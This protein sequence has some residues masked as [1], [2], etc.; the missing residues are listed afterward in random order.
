MSTDHEAVGRAVERIAYANI[1]WQTLKVVTHGYPKRWTAFVGPITGTTRATPG[2]ALIAL[3]DKIDPSWETRLRE[4]CESLGL[5]TDTHRHHVLGEYEGA[6]GFSSV[7]I[8]ER[9]EAGKYVVDCLGSD[10][11]TACRAALAA[12]DVL[13]PPEAS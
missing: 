4:R 10:R 13:Y 8:R 3:A 9:G 6:G 5:D 12:L 2:E 7:T 11:E 1:A